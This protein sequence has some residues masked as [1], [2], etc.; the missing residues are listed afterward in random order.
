LASLLPSSNIARITELF[1]TK[2]TI[3]SAIIVYILQ[4]KYDYII[5]K[6]I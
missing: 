5:I 6:I 1:F 2:E 4:K 3:E